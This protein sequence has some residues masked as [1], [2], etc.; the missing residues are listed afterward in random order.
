MN[1][2]LLD[3]SE[4]R[5]LTSEELAREGVLNRRLE[6]EPNS[7]QPTMDWLKDKNGYIEQDTVEL[8]PAMPNLEEICHKFID[9]HR[10]D[11][12]EIRFVLLG[13]GIF[14]IRSSKDQWMRVKVE[15][16][17]LIVVPAGRYHRFTLTDKKM[18]RCVRL[19]KDK[20][21]WVPYYRAPAVA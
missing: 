6:T 7:Y 3:D 10:H 5:E 15:Q 2:F 17:D 16:G 4:R 14:D 1:A 19:F 9:E 13:E 21:G 18:I 8:K 12:D 20:S 11:E